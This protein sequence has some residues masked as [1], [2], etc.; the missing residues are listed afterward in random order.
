MEGQTAA[1]KGQGRGR[2]LLPETRRF[3][4]RSRPLT[5]LK[6]LMA[7]GS[8]GGRRALSVRPATRRTRRVRINKGRGRGRPRPTPAQRKRYGEVGGDQRGALNL[9]NHLRQNV[10]VKK[11]CRRPWSHREGATLSLRHRKGGV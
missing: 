8:R 4:R 1:G 9:G 3:G 7:S 6:A 5:T 2:L 10:F 11:T